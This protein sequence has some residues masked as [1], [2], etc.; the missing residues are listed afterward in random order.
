MGPAIVQLLV[1]ARSRGAQ[2]GGA[3]LTQ[4]AKANQLAVLKSRYLYLKFKGSLM[5]PL[6]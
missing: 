3:Q 4:P 2:P 6:P 5:R 1:E